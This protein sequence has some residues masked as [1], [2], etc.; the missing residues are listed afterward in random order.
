ME[1][2]QLPPSVSAIVELLGSLAS[3]SGRL[4]RHDEDQL[5]A[6]M[7]NVRQRW[8]AVDQRAFQIKCYEVGLTSAS[9]G[10]LVGFLR[11]IQA[12]ASLRPRDRAFRYGGIT[13]QAPPR[14]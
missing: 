13:A 14:P 5:K 2:P 10:A 1:T 12:G 9:T 3:P 6:D 7:M 11:R 8:L 4:R